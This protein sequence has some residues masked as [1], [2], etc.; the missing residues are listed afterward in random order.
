[1]ALSKTPGGFRVSGDSCLFPDVGSGHESG[2][3]LSMGHLFLPQQ[4]LLSGAWS[5]NHRHFPPIVAQKAQDC[6]KES[7]RTRWWF[8]ARWIWI[9]SPAGEWRI[10]QSK[11]PLRGNFCHPGAHSNCPETPR[12]LCASPRPGRVDFPGLGTREVRSRP[13]VPRCFGRGRVSFFKAAFLEVGLGSQRAATQFLLG[14]GSFGKGG[15]PI[16][17]GGGPRVPSVLGLV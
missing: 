14:G 10:H 9:R 7:H 11:R 6:S 13:C 17:L 4:P 12:S 15:H 8:G 5:R 3:L 1:M 2:V 16:F